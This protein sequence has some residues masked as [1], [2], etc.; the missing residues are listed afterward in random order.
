M[1]PILRQATQNYLLGLD[2]EH[3]DREFVAWHR[4]RWFM[5]MPYAAIKRGGHAFSK[6]ELF[7]TYDK[8][9][10]AF[11]HEHKGLSRPLNC[12]SA[13]PKHLKEP[14]FHPRTGAFAVE[15]REE[16]VCEAESALSEPFGLV[17][18]FLRI[19]HLGGTFWINE[20]GAMPP[21]TVRDGRRKVLAEDDIWHGVGFEAK[22]AIRSAELV[23]AGSPRLLARFDP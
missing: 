1:F 8:S 18:H 12:K 3:D 10:C 9:H 2:A 4:R 23:A 13:W 11:H 17:L 15:P 21:E 19:A 5:H 22:N 20:F 16:L 7:I 14:G 6:N